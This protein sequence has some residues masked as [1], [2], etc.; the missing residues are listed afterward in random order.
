MSSLSRRTLLVAALVVCLVLL[1]PTPTDAKAAPKTKANTPPPP[2]PPVEE[3][4]DIT[5]V[6]VDG[7]VDI[8]KSTPAEP[9]A[10]P[11]PLPKGTGYILPKDAKALYKRRL[12]EEIVTF[13]E[14]YGTKE[15]K[16]QP[17][18]GYTYVGITQFYSM[19]SSGPSLKNFIEHQKKMIDLSGEEAKKLGCEPAH[20]TMWVSLNPL[21]V[22]LRD[23][24]KAE[25]D[26]REEAQKKEKEQTKDYIN[27]EEAQRK[28]K[29]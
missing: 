29:E 4:E 7:T 10:E 14:R 15:T 28:G 11:A 9:A 20:N 6:D 27:A 18:V 22:D 2:P 1:Q 3:D 26:Q 24:I 8:N 21:V 25:E 23:I 17:L 5:V 12:I 19:I 16:C 13:S